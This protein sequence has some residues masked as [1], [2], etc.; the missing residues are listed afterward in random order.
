MGGEGGDRIGA[1]V[2]QEVLGERALAL[3][4]RGVA[5]ELL[6]VDDGEVESGPRRVVEEDRVQD[7]APGGGQAER[8]VRDAEDG[9]RLRERFLD[10]AEPLDGLDRAPHVLRIAGPAG[11]G[12]RVADH[13]LGRDPVLPG[14]ERVRA[15]GH[16]ELALARHRHAGGRILVDRAADDRGAETARERQ[17]VGEALLAVLEV[18]R[19]DDRLPLA[20]GERQ[21]DDPRVGRV[22]HERRLHLADELGQEGVHVGELVAIGIGEADVHDPGAALHLA[23]ADLAR[24][25]PLPR[26]DELLELARADH[27]RALAD[28]D[29][30]V[31]IAH[32]EEVDPGDERAPVLGRDARPLPLHHGG[33]RRMCAGVVPQQPPTRLSQ[34]C[35]AKRSST[36]AMPSG[37]SR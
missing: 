30:P 27:V 23:A 16:L 10:Q 8:H 32:L 19:V 11:K 18:H 21:L 12:E 20:V 7:L 33:E 6:G 9:L 22:D 31:V 17:H 26:G 28:E 34:P 29:G 1:P 2:P 25:L 24:L 15:A 35:S 13:V 3:G 5:L 37:V 36:R 4:D 14:H